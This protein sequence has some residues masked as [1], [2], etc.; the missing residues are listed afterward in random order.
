MVR[1]VPAPKAKPAA[2]MAHFSVEGST[3]APTWW[4]MELGFLYC[5]C[6]LCI[7]IYTHNYVC[8]YIYIYILS[9]YVFMTYLYIIIY[10]YIVFL[11][12]KFMWIDVTCEY[13][14]NMCSHYVAYPVYVVT[15]SS[16]YSD[17]TN[18]IYLESHIIWCFPLPI[19]PQLFQND[20]TDSAIIPSPNISNTFEI[21]HVQDG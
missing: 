11:C 17:Q 18:Q 12:F 9:S 21:S 3:M 2:S 19:Y 10:I 7:Y 5:N 1:D 14:F 20:I 8:I 16:I 13:M 6:S 4:K 15:W